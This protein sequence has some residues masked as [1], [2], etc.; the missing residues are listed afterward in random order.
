MA[1]VTLADGL[2]WLSAGLTAFA[3]GLNDAPKVLGLGLAAT[4]VL[5]VPLI[6]AFLLVALAMTAGSLLRGFKVTETLARN[7][8][9]M[10][11][12]EGFAANL[13]TAALV[14]LASRLAL[15]VSTTHV[16][17]AAIIGLGLRRD[18]RQ[19]RW[20]TVRDM[21]LAWVVTLPASALV[22]AIV[23]SLLQHLE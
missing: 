9:P 23:F 14:I 6:G 19:V 18:A 10:A 11:P 2:H 1:G 13:V 17:S 21:L 12:P 15:P 7:V 3:R 8:T 5:N 20:D 22:A 4:V 16:S